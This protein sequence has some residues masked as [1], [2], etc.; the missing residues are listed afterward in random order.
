MPS[1]FDVAIQGAL[2]SLVSS[3]GGYCRYRD[4]WKGPNAVFDQVFLRG[5]AVPCLVAKAMVWLREN[6][7]LPWKLLKAMD[8]AGYSLNYKA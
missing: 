6:S 4:K 7:F 5:C 1:G 3:S 8:L 2:W